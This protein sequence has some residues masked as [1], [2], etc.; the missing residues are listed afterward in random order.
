MGLL[1][2]ITRGARDHSGSSVGLWLE[3]GHRLTQGWGC[4]L[5]RV[6]LGYRLLLLE[7]EFSLEA[8]QR[9]GRGLTYSKGLAGNMGILAPRHQGQQLRHVLFHKLLTLLPV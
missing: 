6:V 5:R 4:R 1:H 2:L 3:L 9:A 8:L 7:T